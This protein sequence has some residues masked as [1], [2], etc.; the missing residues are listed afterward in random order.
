MSDTFIKQLFQ[1]VFIDP[2]NMKNFEI[3]LEEF[4]CIKD[5]FLIINLND[6]LLETSKKHLLR[7]EKISELQGVEVLWKILFSEKI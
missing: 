7:S 1:K 4:N 2:E 5:L 6:K 3:S